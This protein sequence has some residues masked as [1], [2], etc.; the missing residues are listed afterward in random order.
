MVSN[1]SLIKSRFK[2]YAMCYIKLSESRNLLHR[3]ILSSIYRFA[4]ALALGNGLEPKINET[5]KDSGNV[6]VRITSDVVKQV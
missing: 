5:N 2:V 6:I 3:N 1:V 4:M